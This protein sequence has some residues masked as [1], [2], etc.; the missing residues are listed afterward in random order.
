MGRS[1]LYPSWSKRILLHLEVDQKGQKCGVCN[2][3]FGGQVWISVVTP[4]LIIGSIKYLEH[5]LTFVIKRNLKFMH[6]SNF[7]FKCER[8]SVGALPFTLLLRFIKHSNF[9]LNFSKTQK[10]VKST[11]SSSASLRMPVPAAKTL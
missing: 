6:R 3:H 10:G 8:Q 2:S 11:S 1:W 5:I 7:D 9:F 4:T